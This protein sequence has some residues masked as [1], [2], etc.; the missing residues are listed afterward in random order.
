L[1]LL[2]LVLFRVKGTDPE[3]LSTRQLSISFNH[4]AARY[5]GTHFD[6][7]P[8]FPPGEEVDITDRLSYKGKYATTERFPS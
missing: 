3:G 6:E 1:S 4:M 5:C 7:F 2:L 8:A